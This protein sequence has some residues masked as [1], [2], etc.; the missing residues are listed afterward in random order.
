MDELDEN[1][2][3]ESTELK[4]SE[5]SGPASLKQISEMIRRQLSEQQARLQ[6]SYDKRLDG[7]EAVLRD[8]GELVVTTRRAG[9]AGE[10]HD[11]AQAVLTGGPQPQNQTQPQP[12]QNQPQP[13][14][15][16][17]INVNEEAAAQHVEHQVSSGAG[18]GGTSRRKPQDFDG[19]ASWA[20]YRAQFE[21]IATNNRW[22]TRQ[23]AVE[24]A[25]SLKGPALE[26]LACVPLEHLEN[27]EALT[28]VLEQRFGTAHQEQLHRTQLRT[29]VR[30][31]NES[32]QE[33]AL[34]VERLAYLAYPEAP[35]EFRTTIACDQF[36]DA[37]EDTDMQIRVRQSKPTKLRDALANAL[38]YES[39]RRSLKV[40]QWRQ[41]QNSG[42]SNR[43]ASVGTLG[44]QQN[45]DDK[46]DAILSRIQELESSRR[47]PAE[48]RRSNVGRQTGL[49]PC[50]NCNKM[51]HIRR[52]CRLPSRMTTSGAGGSSTSHTSSQG[53][54]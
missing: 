30:G 4:S 15:Q 31:S 2:Q 16:T 21:L 1:A 42:F 3:M 8:L 20:A 28:D 39:L 33:L 48:A 25:A 47:Q 7:I 35:A 38:E 40:P 50:W 46:L 6:E 36:I 29:R 44:P 53:N 52:D 23:K 10:D 18:A 41:G 14:N 9:A 24:L 13:Q 32:L 54:E 17:V 19:S 22:S 51:G 11:A 43:Q 37:L 34:D 45:L 26:T 5:E 12:Q 27:Y 49:G